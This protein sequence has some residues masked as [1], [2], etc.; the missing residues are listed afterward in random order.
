MET[1]FVAHDTQNFGAKFTISTDKFTAV[2]AFQALLCQTIK[3]ILS[4]SKFKREF[5]QIK[6]KLSVRRPEKN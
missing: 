3:F 2:R 5:V 4:I 1:C 6:V